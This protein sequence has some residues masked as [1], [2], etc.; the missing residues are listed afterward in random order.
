MISVDRGAHGAGGDDGATGSREVGLGQSVGRRRSGA[1]EVGDDVIEGLGR[2][3]VRDRADCHDERVVRWLADGAG[4][5]TT[6]RRAD[7][8]GDAGPPGPLDRVVERVDA[9]VLGRVR[10][11]RQVD[12]LDVVGVLEGHRPLQCGHDVRDVRGAVL[13]GDLQRDQVDVGGHAAHGPARRCTAAG[14]QAGEEG[15]VAVVIDAVTLTAPVLAVH[16]L[17][18]QVAGGVD[19]GVD[20][21]DANTATGPA[22]APGL[23]RADDGRVDGAGHAGVLAVEAL[24]VHLAGD[25]DVADVVGERPEQADALR[26][27]LRREAADDRQLLRD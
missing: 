21:S 23:V 13:A 3:A 12:D 24:E 9:V 20:D 8:H 15:A 16:D 14:D 2:G 27:D 10:A 26:G 17:A 22:A 25:R 7:D 1:G 6:V 18:G 19:A 11:E 5:R 4:V